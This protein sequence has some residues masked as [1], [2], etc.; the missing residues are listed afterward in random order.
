MIK[1]LKKNIALAQR[2]RRLAESGATV[3]QISKKVSCGQGSAYRWCRDIFEEKERSRV[4]RYQKA[5]ELYAGGKSSSDVGKI[6]LMHSSVVRVACAGIMRQVSGARGE[7]NGSWAGGVTKVQELIRKSDKYLEWRKRVFE[8][9]NYTC[10][11]TGQKG[12]NLCVDHIKPFSVIIR[13]NRIKTLEDAYGC[14][15]LWDIKNGRTLSEKYH[16]TL[17][18]YGWKMHNVLRKSPVL[19]TGNVL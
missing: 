5:R 14:I 9:D 3:A 15:E 8:R 10:V 7:K 19:L 18:T 11:V 17:D 2:A 16:R 4:A 12:G 13:E 1:P 6:L